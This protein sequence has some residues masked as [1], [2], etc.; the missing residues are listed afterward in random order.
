M[1][2][3][4]TRF[5]RSG[6]ASRRSARRCVRARSGVATPRS[7]PQLWSISKPQRYRR[8]IYRSFLD[9]LTFY[10]VSRSGGH[11]PAR[12]FDRS[13]GRSCRHNRSNPISKSGGLSGP[14]GFDQS[15]L[16][17]LRTSMARSSKPSNKRALMS[18]LPKSS[19]SVSQW[20]PQP[21]TAAIMDTD[22]PVTPDVGCR[23][24]KNVH[25]GRVVGNPPC[26]PAR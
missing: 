25:A 20:V 18:I 2:L 21:Q 15:T 22:H 17:I 9:F 6:R 12:S 7:S 16:S 3:L 8:P 11:L 19:P 4:R 10:V 23:L 14:R 1:L 5:P 24:T 26:K 13:F